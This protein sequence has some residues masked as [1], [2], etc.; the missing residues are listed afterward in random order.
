MNIVAIYGIM[1]MEVNSYLIVV[2]KSTI[3]GQIFKKKVFQV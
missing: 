1:K 2:T 3:V